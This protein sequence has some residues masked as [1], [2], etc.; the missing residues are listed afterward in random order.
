MGSRCFDEKLSG[1]TLVLNKDVSHRSKLYSHSK[2]KFSKYYVSIVKERMT[3]NEYK[4]VFVGFRKTLVSI[5][6]PTRNSSM[7]RNEMEL[8]FAVSYVNCID[9]W[10][11][12]N[13]EI[14]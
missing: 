10:K 5:F 14:T 9:G 7:S 8:L 2:L 12:F 4:S 1:D 3:A 11:L 6:S 13:T